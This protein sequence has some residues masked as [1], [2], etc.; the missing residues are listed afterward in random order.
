VPRS[1]DAREPTVITFGSIQGG[2]S[3]NIIPDRVE[4]L[5]TLRTLSDRATGQVEERISQIARGLAAASRATIDVT[6]RRG[7]AAVDN[8]PVVTAI[9]V[10]AAGEVV[11]PG[12]VE[13]IRLPSMGGEDFSGYLKHVPGCLLR[14][15][16]AALDRPRHALHS[17]QFDIDEAALAIGA[18]VLTHSTVLL[19]DLPGRRRT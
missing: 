1:F 4:L 3:P 17:P 14:L 5:G 11:G 12:N 9:C 15:G 10:Q 16:V 7:T 13:E 19:R 8:D 6:Y 18:K 2:T